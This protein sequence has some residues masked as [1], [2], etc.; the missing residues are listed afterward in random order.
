MSVIRN[1]IRRG[2][3][4][5]SV[6]LMRIAR[7]VQALDGVEVAGLMIG[8]PANLEILRE[9]GVLDPQG[10]NAGPGD[11]V[12]ALRA[13]TAAQAD[14]A[15]AQARQAM[16]KPRASTAASQSW[17]PRTLRSALTETPA[18]NLALI[19]VPGDFAIA[20]ARKAIRSGLDVMIF[21]DNVPLTDEVELKREA[22]E[23]GRLVM[24]PD[25]GTAIIGGA[26]LAF[27]NV[28]PRGNIGIIGASGT[29]IQE[30]SC[31][32]AQ[33][34][35]GIS[36]AIGTGGRDL[37]AEIG[38]ITTLMAIDLLDADPATKHIVIVSKP[39]AAVV[40]AKVLE[41]VGRSSKPFT[42]C[43]LGD[44]EREMPKNARAART[45]ADAARFATGSVATDKEQ[46]LKALR[47]G[48]IRGLFA[49]GTLAAEAQLVA[50]GHGLAVTSNAPVPGATAVGDLSMQHTML[51][52]GADEY[53]RGRPH[54]M[55]EPAVRDEPLAAAL[56]DRA[57]AVILLDCVLGFGGHM[58][59]AGHLAS[60]LR[61]RSKNG[62]TI[63]A[64]V[65][66][67]D[68]DPQNRSVQVKKLEA[69]DMIVAPSNAI[70]A[71]MA[72]E[73]VRRGS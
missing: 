21:S 28:V 62:P 13:K 52:L 17:Q 5:D 8:T 29:G 18:A 2:A 37:K 58:D 30:V 23:L 54:P 72:A 24:G 25:C 43:F 9:A 36:H 68:G 51:D 11:I 22:R 10:E 12:I 69:S 63:I 35:R 7:S 64:S 44:A 46:R 38:G 48:V 56:A 6:A 19:S 32:I 45:L 42:I 15:L 61:D 14:A 55:I 41:R 71:A 4:Q 39:P 59:P 31:L 3:Y 57:V 60:R 53:T 47:K 33:A 66:G 34:G 50:L 65:T 70:A 16:D 49:G 1:E 27:A 20:E 40:A 26:P 73:V 67:T